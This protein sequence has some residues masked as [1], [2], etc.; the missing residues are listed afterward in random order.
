[1]TRKEKADGA[2]NTDCQRSQHDRT[3]H[4]SCTLEMEGSF[5]MRMFEICG[6]WLGRVAVRR[7]AASGPWSLRECKIQMPHNS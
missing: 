7:V 6:D 4:D 5:S 2:A 1:M 3:E